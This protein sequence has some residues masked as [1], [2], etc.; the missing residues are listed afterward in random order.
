MKVNLFLTGVLCASAAGSRSQVEAKS[1]VNHFSAPL[2]RGMTNGA[3]CTGVKNIFTGILDASKAGVPSQS[4]FSR[5]TETLVTTQRDSPA[6][7]AARAIKG[8]PLSFAA[9]VVSTSFVDRLFAVPREVRHQNLKNLAL[10]I[11][12]MA[13]AKEVLSDAPLPPQ[14]KEVLAYGAFCAGNIAQGKDPLRTV[15][16]VTGFAV[17]AKAVQNHLAAAK[18]AT[19]KPSEQGVSASAVSGFMAPSSRK[20]SDNAS[21]RSYDDF[22]RQ[23]YGIKEGVKFWEG[24]DGS[25]FVPLDPSEMHHRN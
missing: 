18:A 3:I 12:A 22:I 2:T 19:Q 15:I 11:A 8:F 25:I 24:P 4:S 9:N 16:T 17:G 14:V 21:A 13:V 7:M 1:P 5:K 20:T 6:S 23:R 10:P